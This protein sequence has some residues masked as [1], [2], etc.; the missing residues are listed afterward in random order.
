[1]ELKT[2][3]IWSNDDMTTTFAESFTNDICLIFRFSLDV[4]GPQS[5][6]SRIAA[7]YN[8]LPVQDEHA[9]FTDISL[10]PEEV[11]SLIQQVWLQSTA[12]PSMNLQDVVVEM[13]EDT[14]QQLRWRVP[15]ESSFPQYIESVPPLGRLFESG[16]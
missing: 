16:V 4:Q 13:Y 15:H 7:C 1:M 8:H 6:T 2:G 14:R 12:Y 10:M 9:S 5:L 3:L 11:Y